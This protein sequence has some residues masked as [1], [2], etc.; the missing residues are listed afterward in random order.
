MDEKS[1][2]PSLSGQKLIISCPVR[3][4]YTWK[5]KGERVRLGEAL[6]EDD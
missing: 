1:F 3:I 6:I 2:S 5:M 4:I